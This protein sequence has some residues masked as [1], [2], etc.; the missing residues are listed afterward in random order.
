MT[1][2][3]TD[4]VNYLYLQI[5]M[6]RPMLDWTLVCKYLYTAHRRDCITTGFDTYSQNPQQMKHTWTTEIFMDH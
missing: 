2:R 4:T 1:G 6:N 5:K 3:W